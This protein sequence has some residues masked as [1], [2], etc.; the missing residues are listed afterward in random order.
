M[1]LLGDAALA[2]GA[3][4]G[5][6][7]Y[8]EVKE[9]L[10]QGLVAGE[11]RP[12]TAIPSEARLAERFGVSLGTVRK[13]IDE[14]VAEKILLRRQGRGTFVATHTPD[15]T[16]FY[17]FHVVG[18]DGRKETPATELLQFGR[19][20]ADAEEAAKLGLGRGERV[21][22]IRNL[23]R[24]GGDPVVIDDIVIAA[25]LV[26]GLDER[27]FAQREETIYGL[28]QARY[29]INVIRASERLSAVLTDAEAA[30]LLDVPP[31]T[32]LLQIARVAFTYQD[33]PVE[34]RRSLVD[35]TA[36]EYAADLVKQ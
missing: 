22:R 32:P 23:L 10:T 28:Y 15:R 2:Q 8:K 20:R 30:R 29:G 25:Q 14:L 34:L 24:L 26:P 4:G 5:Q 31:S 11:W 19:G 33:R 27:A 1:N 9:R 21:L 13:A 17:F 7:L 35:T 36:H 6:P 3:P 12:G 16:L 18:R